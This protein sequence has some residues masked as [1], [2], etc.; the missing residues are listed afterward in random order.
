MVSKEDLENRFANFSNKE[1][2]DIIENKFKYTDLALSV[3]LSELSKRQINAHDFE[4][5]KKEQINEWSNKFEKLTLIELSFFQKILFYV[6]CFSF[7]NFIFKRNLDDDG[8]ELKLFQADYYSNFGIVFLIISVLLGS[9][10]IFSD[11]VYVIF[12]IGFV[13]AYLFDEYFNRE[14]LIEI[15]KKKYAMD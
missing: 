9:I 10:K 13:I 15:I 12:I 2:L 8:F 14:K 3:A 5:Y 7:L 6:L 4:N 1:L 11:F